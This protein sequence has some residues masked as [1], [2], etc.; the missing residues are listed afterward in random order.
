MGFNSVLLILNDA[1]DRIKDDP[2]FGRKCHDACLTVTNRGPVDI[3]SGGHVNAATVYASHH[4]DWNRVII[5]GGN[6]M[7][8]TDAGVHRSGYIENDELL[9]LA[10]KD[11]ADRLGYRVSKKPTK[12]KT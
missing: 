7:I 10:L 8:V 3:S 11:F 4:A 12:K 9:L 1:L 5:A 6:R 2:D